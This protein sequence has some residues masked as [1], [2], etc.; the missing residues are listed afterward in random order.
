MTNESYFKQNETYFKALEDEINLAKTPIQSIQSIILSELDDYKSFSNK[1]N[2]STIPVETI[3][4]FSTFG[5]KTFKIFEVSKETKKANTYDK[6]KDETFELSEKKTKTEKEK[7]YK[8]NDS[9]NDNEKDSPFFD[10]LD[11]YRD[12]K[13]NLFYDEYEKTNFQF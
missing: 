3:N 11:S 8:S 9:I 12:E 7:N 6:Q 4:F 13:D 1:M 10:Y 5:P 2:E